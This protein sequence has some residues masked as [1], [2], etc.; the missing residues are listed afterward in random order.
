M[1]MKKILISAVVAAIV[2]S[3]CANTQYV[4]GGRVLE[5]AAPIT[6]GID[7][8]DLEKAASDAVDSL[9]SSGS[10]E[11]PGGG[12]YVVTMGKVTNDTTQ[13]IDTGLLTKKIRIAMLKSGKAVMTTAVAAGGAEDSMSHDV[14]EL[15]ENDEFAQNTIAKKGTLLAPDMSLSGKIIQR[16]IKTT[17]N[18]QLVEYY[19]QLTLTQLQTGLAFWEDEININKIG[20]NKSVSW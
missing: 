10:L 15:R 6:M 4:Q 13:R 7:H 12:R 14:R 19:F 17:N 3:G 8:T 20:S 1:N 5:N 18:K 2:F 9:L 11:R 16:N